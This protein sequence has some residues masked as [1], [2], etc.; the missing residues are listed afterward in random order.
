MVD[1]DLG[2]VLEWIN[3]T[4]IVADSGLKLGFQALEDFLDSGRD[5]CKVAG[6]LSSYPV[7]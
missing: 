6:K 2:L 7:Q 1:A 4:A 5:L 3:A